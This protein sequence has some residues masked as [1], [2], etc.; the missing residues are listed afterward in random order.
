MMLICSTIS[1][2]VERVKEVCKFSSQSESDRV[3]SGMKWIGL[4]SSDQATVR[5]STT[6]DTLCAQLEKLMKYQP[7]ERDLVMLQHKFI[8]E[9]KDGSKVG[10]ISTS[11]LRGRLT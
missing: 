7:E 8:V 2:L 10:C 4:F 3:I 9:W 5:A 6:L 11:H 1:S